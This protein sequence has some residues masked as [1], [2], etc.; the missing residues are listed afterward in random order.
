MFGPALRLTLWGWLRFT[1][2]WEGGDSCG[3]GPEQ[4]RAQGWGQRQHPWCYQ[5]SAA[6]SPSACSPCDPTGLNGALSSAQRSRSPQA[7][8]RHAGN[9]YDGTESARSDQTHPQMQM[10][11]DDT[12]PTPPRMS[13][14]I[15]LARL[16]SAPHVAARENP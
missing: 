15:Q 14:R 16:P 1:M 13:V 7:E 11:V 6:P 9:S 2:G 10:Y 3:M 12:R 5:E 8:P 4:V